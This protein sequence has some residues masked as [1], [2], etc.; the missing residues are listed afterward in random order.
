MLEKTFYP[1]QVQAGRR[2]VESLLLHDGEVVTMLTSRQ[3]G[4]TELFGALM[5]ALAVILPRLAMLFPKSWHLNLTDNQG[6]YRGFRH[7]FKVGIYA[8]RMDQSGI[9]FDR[10]KKVLETQSTKRILKD[11]GLSHD[12]NNGNTILLS[13]SSRILCESA[14]EQSKIEGATHNLVV[15]EEA[16]DISDMKIRKSI[17]PMVASTMGTIVK[18]G[19]ATTRMCD[20]YSTIQ[21]NRRAELLNNQQNHFFFPWTVGAKYNSLYA[22]YIEGEKRRLGEDS[23]EFQT[24]YCGRFIFERG[25]FVTQEALFHQDIAQQYGPFSEITLKDLPERL[26]HYSLVVGIDWGSSNDSTVVT[27]GAVNWNT[28][29]TAGFNETPDGASTDW[30]T[31]YRKHILGWIEF[32]GDSYES[33]FWEIHSFLCQLRGL[34]KVV[35]DSNS[36][37]RPIF[38]RFTAAFTDRDIEIVGFDFAAKRKSDAYRLF[39][40]DLQGQRITFPAG[41]KAR[42]EITYRKFVGQMLDLR[43]EYENGLMKVHHPDEKGARDDYGDSAMLFALGAG[44]P[45]TKGVDFSGRNPFF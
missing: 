24:S 17:S 23:D 42:Q 15:A 8:P 32:V 7:G 38:D 20:F 40:G 12:L 14:S 33:Q 18:V 4:K 39:S 34:R 19:T 35:M 16:Q 6:A 31:F 9:M 10:V 21:Y 22:K 11:L 26:R 36:C 2:V 3:V 30:F 25:M 28:P 13:N 45:S 37:G 1:Y 5:A 41:A 44:T 27:L 43:K 29:M